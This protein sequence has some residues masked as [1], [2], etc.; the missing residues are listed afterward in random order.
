[1]VAESTLS[2][3][4]LSKQQE[5]NKRLVLSSDASNLSPRSPCAGVMPIK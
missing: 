5:I 1:M 4:E 2:D 3:E